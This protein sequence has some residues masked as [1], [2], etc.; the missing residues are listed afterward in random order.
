MRAPLAMTCRMN[1]FS[2][3]P[4]HPCI[5]VLRELALR[6][7]RGHPT[8]GFWCLGF[9]SA[10]GDGPPVRKLHALV[11]HCLLAPSRI[12]PRRPAHTTAIAW[13]PG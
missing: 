7:F 13:L 9:V 1:L 3:P 6:G 12:L 4:T 10:I 8:S 2:F 5:G 11:V